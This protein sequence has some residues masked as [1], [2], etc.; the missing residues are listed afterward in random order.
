MP[1]PDGSVAGLLAALGA[2]GGLSMLDLMQGC[3]DIGVQRHVRAADHFL[4]KL[5]CFGPQAQAPQL[6]NQRYADINLALGLRRLASQ[7]VDA[8][9]AFRLRGFRE[10][11]EAFTS[12]Y[13][14]ECTRPATYAEQRLANPFQRHI[15][16][17]P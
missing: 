15:L 17:G 8:Y 13:E 10:Y 4:G 16:R 11:P 5:T 12:D 1:R 6:L 3:G 2:A 14:E 9:R 7:D